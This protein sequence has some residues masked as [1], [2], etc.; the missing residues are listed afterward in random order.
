[1]GKHSAE[2]FRQVCA[3]CGIPFEYKFSKNKR[4][5]IF[6]SRACILGPRLPGHAP[7]VFKVEAICQE[8]GAATPKKCH[9]MRWCQNCVPNKSARARMQRYGISQPAWERMCAEYDGKC[10]ICRERGAVALDHCHSTGRP[11]GALCD[12]C[13]VAL[14]ALE[15]PDWERKAREY[16]AARGV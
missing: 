5:R 16:L 7:R 15:R 10:W 2:I 13:N 11:R 12:G 8:C 4:H 14:H 6:C 9:N 1:M 3:R